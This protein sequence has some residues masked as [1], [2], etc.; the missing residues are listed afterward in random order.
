MQSPERQRQPLLWQEEDKDKLD[1]IVKKVEQELQGELAS[2]D[3][4]V[5]IQAA[6]ENVGSY[7]AV[8]AEDTKKAA[9]FLIS[10]PEEYR[11]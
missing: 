7:E 1:S 5:F 4:G 6:Y 10:L 11:G 3:A 2:K 9:A 8:T